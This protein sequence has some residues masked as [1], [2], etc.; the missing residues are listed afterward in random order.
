MSEQV[1]L[2]FSAIS[3]RYDVGNDILSFG[4]HR[5]WKRYMVRRAQAP[6]GGRI[7]DLATGTGDIALL[8]SDAVGPEGEV[9]GV[10]FCADMI[11]HARARPKNHRSNMRFE[12]GDAMNLRFGNNSFDVSSISFGIRNVDDPVKALAEMHRVVKP[13]GHVVVLEFGQPRGMFGSM[14]RI[15]SDHILPFIGGIITGDREAYSYLNRTAAQFPCRGEFTDMMHRA[16]FRKA[17][18]KA[19]FGGIAFLYIGEVE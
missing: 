5:I 18:W 14:Y 2:M 19:L 12:V 10:D 7:L 11:E 3:E 4:V 6:R 17:T 9:I 16:G 1:R 8:F 15:Y 13:G